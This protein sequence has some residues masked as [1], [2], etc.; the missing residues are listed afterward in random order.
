[1]LLGLFQRISKKKSY[2][3]KLYYS[4]TITVFCIFTSVVVGVVVVGVVVVGVVVVSVVGVVVVITIKKKFRAFYTVNGCS[5]IKDTRRT[6]FLF[7]HYALTIF[8]CSRPI[9]LVVSCTA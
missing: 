4:I 5:N 6:H 8:S 1:V 2:I 9:S 7:Q 3:V